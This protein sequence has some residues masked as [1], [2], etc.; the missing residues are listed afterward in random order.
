MKRQTNRNRWRQFP[1]RQSLLRS[2]SW[3][4]LRIRKRIYLKAMWRLARSLA[5]RK[6]LRLFIVVINWRWRQSCI[7]WRHLLRSQVRI[8]WRLQWRIAKVGEYMIIILRAEGVTEG[9]RESVRGIGAWVQRTDR[10]DPG[11]C[12]IGNIRVVKHSAGNVRRECDFADGTRIL[13]AILHGAGS[14]SVEDKVLL[15]YN[16]IR[17]KLHSSRLVTREETKELIKF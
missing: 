15:L 12:L 2:Q 11:E 16:N 3:R 14:G 9:G 17:E 5:W 10:A 13:L 1:S 4:L 7:F 6:A 8:S